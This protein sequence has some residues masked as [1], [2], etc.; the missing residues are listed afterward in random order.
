MWAAGSS[1]KEITVVY[2]T[3]NNDVIIIAANKTVGIINSA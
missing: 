2:G 1:T 3:P